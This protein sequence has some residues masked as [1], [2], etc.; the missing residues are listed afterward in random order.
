MS[1]ATRRSAELSRRILYGDKGITLALEQNRSLKIGWPGG[2]A[3]PRS[4]DLGFAPGLPNNLTMRYLGVPGSFSFS[5]N[6]ANVS[7][8]G[9]ARSYIGAW[10][11]D[12]RIT[13]EGN[14][15]AAFGYAMQGGKGTIEGDAGEDAGL[16]MEGGIIHIKGSTGPNIGNSMQGGMILVSG[17]VG[18]NP[19]INM[20]AG[21]V[22]INGKT[23][24]PGPGAMQVSPDQ[25]LDQLDKEL[26]DEFADAIALVPSDGERLPERLPH[27][28][29]GEWTSLLPVCDDRAPRRQPDGVDTITLIEGVENR[30]PLG[31]R[32][33]V[34]LT[35]GKPGHGGPVLDHKRSE[36]RICTLTTNLLREPDPSADVLLCLSQLPSLDDEALDGLVALIQSQTEVDRRIILVGGVGDLPLLQRTA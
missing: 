4:G 35:S 6:Q 31:L 8:E 18:A 5:L 29:L 24:R 21:C 27:P 36:P 23:P 1:E 13:I 32:A 28:A 15:G 22:L 10:M 34:I 26:R 9:N 33:A 19:G 30:L 17:S 7:I 11:I 14:T 12:G 2:E 3:K 16:L 25:W 20:Q